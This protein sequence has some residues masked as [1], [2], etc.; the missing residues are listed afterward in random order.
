MKQSYPEL[1]RS[2]IHFHNIFTS[3]PF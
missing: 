2:S 3:N 1:N